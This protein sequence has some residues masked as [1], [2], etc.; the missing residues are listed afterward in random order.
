MQSGCGCCG[1]AVNVISNHQHRQDELLHGPDRRDLGWV[2]ALMVI[3]RSWMVS[4]E[5]LP[6]S[7]MMC[8]TGQAACLI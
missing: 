1:A 5:A 7:H 4:G 3:W 6:R 2:A 8:L